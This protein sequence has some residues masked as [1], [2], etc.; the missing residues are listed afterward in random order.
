MRKHLTVVLSALALL[1]GGV[2]VSSAQTAGAPPRW[3]K[4]NCDI[5][6][7]MYIDYTADAQG[8]PTR[9][10]AARPYMRADDTLVKQVRHHHRPTRWL[11]V[12]PTNRIRAALTMYKG[13]NGF[14]VDSVEKCAG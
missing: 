11:V 10:K 3:P 8:A 2:T 5:H 12:K 9:R 1:I 7:M 14:L 13:E 6:S 4:K